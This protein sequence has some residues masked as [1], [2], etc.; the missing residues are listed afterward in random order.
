MWVTT[1][2]TGTC[3]LSHTGTETE[4]P[5]FSFPT[6]SSPHGTTSDGCWKNAAECGRP[7]SMSRQDATY[8]IGTLLHLITF[9]LLLNH[10]EICSS[11][12]SSWQSV[13]PRKWTHTESLQNL[14][15]RHL[16]LLSLA[17]SVAIH[18]VRRVLRL[19]LWLRGRR[20]LFHRGRGLWRVHDGARIDLWEGESRRHPWK[21]ASVHQSLF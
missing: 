8:Y 20:H 16:G 13:K 4:S 10:L 1:T 6:S 21:T 9:V 3:T 11:K 19:N 18:C 7:W 17:V 5:A 12:H 2:H 14:L 15:I